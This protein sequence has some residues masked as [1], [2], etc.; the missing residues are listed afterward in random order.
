MTWTV[1]AN[2]TLASFYR[3]SRNGQ[4]EPMQ[5][6]EHPTGRA[7]GHELGSDRPGRCA[8][9]PGSRRAAFEPHTDPTDVDRDH[10]GREI[11]DAL[12][13]AVNDGRCDKI[14]LVAPPR[15]LGRLRAQLPVALAARVI[16]S[17]PLDLGRRGAAHIPE[18]LLAARTAQADWATRRALPGLPGAY[19]FARA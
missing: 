16:E 13:S 18:A 1:I 6:I 4:L 14:V 5:V 19:G 8:K 11:V 10:F 3:E 7:R 15:M 9:G 12:L 2:A 17:F